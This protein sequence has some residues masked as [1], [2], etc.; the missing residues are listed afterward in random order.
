[1]W[2]LSFHMGGENAAWPSNYENIP[3]KL[4]HNASKYLLKLTEFTNYM[5]R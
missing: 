3:S 2:S 1:M 4:S 5:K